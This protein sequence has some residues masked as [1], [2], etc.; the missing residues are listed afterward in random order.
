MTKISILYPRN[1]GSRFDMSYYVDVHM[2]ISIELLAA[3]P[4]FKGVSVERGLVLPQT[5]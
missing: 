5:E 4:G 1:Q 3:R 2:P